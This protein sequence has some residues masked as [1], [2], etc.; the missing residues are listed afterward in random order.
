MTTRRVLTAMTGLLCIGL[1]PADATT[2][3]YDVTNISANTWEYTYAVKNDTLG[4][5]IEEFTVYFESGLYQNLVI[6]DVNAVP[7]WDPLTV[8]PNNFLNNDGFYDALAMSSGLAPGNGIGGFTVRFEFLGTGMPGSQFFE[9]VDPLDFTVL[10]SGQTS[11]VPLPAA[12][13]LLGSG[14]IGLAAFA[15]RRD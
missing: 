3:H 15:R 12:I 10:D 4:F 1:Q 2:I 5:E 14:I 8:E 11:L 9:V 6:N 13:W 7:G